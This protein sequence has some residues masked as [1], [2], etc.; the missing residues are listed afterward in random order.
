[1]RRVAKGLPALFGRF[2]VQLVEAPVWMAG[3]VLADQP[4]L[5]AR[6]DKGRYG[7]A[8]HLAVGDADL[9]M[10]PIRRRLLAFHTV[11]PLPNFTLATKRDLRVINAALCR[12][13]LQEVASHPDDALEVS[14]LIRSIDRYPAS[15]LDDGTMKRTF[16]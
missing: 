5:H 11:K 10:V 3:F 8:G 4:V 9:I 14:Q 6:R 15:A 16:A 2:S 7:F 1:M 12:N 13:A